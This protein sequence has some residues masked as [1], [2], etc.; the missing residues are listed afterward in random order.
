MRFSNRFPLPVF[1]VDKLEQMEAHFM[2]FGAGP[3][4]CP[5]MN[6]ALYEAVLGTAFLA[7][8]FDF[9]LNCPAAEVE[10][11]KNFACTPNKMPVSITPAI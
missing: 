11:I 6:L 8:F 2:P 5:G 7:Y 9:Q 3:R 10:R 1:V 4:I